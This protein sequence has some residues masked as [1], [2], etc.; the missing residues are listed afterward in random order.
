MK[1]LQMVRSRPL[2]LYLDT[3]VYGGYFDDEF[4][5]DTIKLF[6]QIKRDRSKIL[7]STIVLDEIAGAPKNVQELLYNL[8]HNSTEY[9]EISEEIENLHLAYINSKVV[10]SLHNSDA[11]HIA[12]ASVVG[13][14]III[15]WNFKHIV[16]FEKIKGY[17]AVNL[18]N[19]YPQIP[20]HSP[21]EVISNEEN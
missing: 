5:E 10:S 17:H 9:F 4:K 1:T 16:Q 21:T 13:A 14:D 18:I 3:S 20:I 15:S 6:S 7:I 11:L 2:R 19:N 8:P 12:A